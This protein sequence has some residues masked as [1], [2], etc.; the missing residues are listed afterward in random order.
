MGVEGP[1]QRV[2][3]EHLT[4][5]T[6]SPGSGAEDLDDHSQSSN[7]RKIVLEKNRRGKREKRLENNAKEM[8]T[9]LWKSDVNFTFDAKAW[10]QACQSDFK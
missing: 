7:V 4:V 9:C 2:D 3:P 8:E 5:A 1:H 10:G 6:R